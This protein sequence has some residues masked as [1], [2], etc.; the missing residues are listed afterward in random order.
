[1]STWSSILANSAA[2]MNDQD[3]ATYTDAVLLAYLNIALSELEEIYELNNIPVTN[4]TSAI[5]NVPAGQTVV[6]FNNTLAQ[7]PPDLVEI[8]ELFESDEGQNVWTP[9][10]KKEFLTTSL[11]GDR[12]PVAKFGVWA[13]INQEIHLVESN[14]DNDIKMDYIASL[15]PELSVPALNSVI[16]IVNI[17]T[18]LQY[19]V[20]A[21]A[22]EFV[23]ENFTRADKLNIFGAIAMERSLGISIKGKQPIA[24]RRRPFRASFKRRRVVT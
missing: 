6:A 13:W 24:V 8:Q 14:Q 12:T 10:V 9:V 11:I 19:R 4:R 16:T 5:I 1:M 2:L 17:E 23:E 18:F 21:L 15:F 7:L 20:A 22:A 3:R